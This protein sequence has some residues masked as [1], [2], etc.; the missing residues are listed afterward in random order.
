MDDLIV[1][2]GISDIV[3]LLDSKR[4]CCCGVLVAKRKTMWKFSNGN[5]VCIS[6]KTQ[7]DNKAKDVVHKLKR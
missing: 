5:Y 3:N 6:C 7:L 4:C 2:E 1:P